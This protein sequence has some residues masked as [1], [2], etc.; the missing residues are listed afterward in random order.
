MQVMIGVSI[1]A[2]LSVCSAASRADL[3]ID[4]VYSIWGTWVKTSINTSTSRFDLAVN[5]EPR[6]AFCF[7]VVLI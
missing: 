5:T 3:G 4:L 6:V 2:S 1:W 7:I